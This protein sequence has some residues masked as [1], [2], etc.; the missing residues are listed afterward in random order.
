MFIVSPT[1]NKRMQS[2]R[3]TRYTSET[4]ADAERYVPR[5]MGNF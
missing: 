3:S 1:A 2:D 5:G 4:A